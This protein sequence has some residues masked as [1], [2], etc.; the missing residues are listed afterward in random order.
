MGME[1]AALQMEKM[2]WSW[3]RLGCVQGTY[4]PGD[5]I[6]RKYQSVSYSFSKFRDPKVYLSLT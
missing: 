6:W 1:K 5:G 2:A 3:G 4:I